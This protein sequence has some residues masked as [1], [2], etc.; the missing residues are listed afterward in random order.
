MITRTSHNSN[1]QS[2]GW[3]GDDNNILNGERTNL[4]GSG[5]TTWGTS[6][7]RRSRM[8]ASGRVSNFGCFL[9]GNANTVDGGAI[10]IKVIAVNTDVMVVDQATGQ[11]TNTD[12]VLA[13]G[14]TD[15]LWFGYIQGDGSID[16]QMWTARIDYA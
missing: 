16:G 2:T 5:F 6:G 11:F 8:T 4:I 12:V 15:G 9:T 13:F 14:N 7:T 1:T 3:F 10:H